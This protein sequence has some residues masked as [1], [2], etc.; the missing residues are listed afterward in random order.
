MKNRNVTM[1][2]IAKEV[3]VSVAT[4]SYVLNYSEKEKI[5]HDTRLKVF[6][7]A[8]RLKYTPNMAARAL[9]GRKV[10]RQIGI[11]ADLAA[12]ETSFSHWS[13]LASVIHFQRAIEA[14][15]Y[16]AVLLSLENVENSPNLT[17]RMVDGV[18][19]LSLGKTV[20]NRYTSKIYVPIVMIECD[21]ENSLFYHVYRDADATLRLAHEML[22][23]SFHV[24]TPFP[25]F[26]KQ[27]LEN[28]L[29]P[30]A[31]DI[32]HY[33]SSD[34]LSRHILK[35][36][37]GSYVIYSETL[38]LMAERHIRPWQCVVV[39][40]NIKSNLLGKVYRCIYDNSQEM[41]DFAMKLMDRILRLE[42]DPKEE[43]NLY[44]EPQTVISDE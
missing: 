31:L 28:N 21:N 36:P 41:A 30:Y 39:T 22:G 43:H 1:K 7:A 44:I 6:E 25:L 19:M 11:L 37:G 2:D 32:Y 26:S 42:P 5:S 8:K 4:V 14:A 17:D 10:K 9:A 33:Q 29:P 38:A 15:G 18:F 16:D 12:G 13:T 34:D 27:G 40:Q 35:D 3:G 24:L 23:T 20:S